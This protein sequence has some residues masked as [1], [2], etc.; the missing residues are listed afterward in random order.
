[1]QKSAPFELLTIQ[2][3]NSTVISLVIAMIVLITTEQNI[4]I[5]SWAFKIEL[6]VLSVIG[7]GVF[8]LCGIINTIYSSLYLNI[9]TLKI[10]KIIEI[11]V[12]DIY[13]VIL[14]LYSLPFINLT[15]FIAMILGIFAIIISEFWK[16]IISKY[17]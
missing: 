1:M 5:V 15:Y 2:Y 14:S 4:T 12:N 6:T 10:I 16:A 3:I 13:A 8:G 7:F 9:N 17:K 11:P